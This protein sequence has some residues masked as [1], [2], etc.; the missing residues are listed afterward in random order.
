MLLGRPL[1]RAL[2]HERSAQGMIFG[3]VLPR[4]RVARQDAMA[5]RVEACD[6]CA[7]GL[8]RQDKA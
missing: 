8:G 3:R 4:H 7:A 5:S 6:L 1:R 2:G